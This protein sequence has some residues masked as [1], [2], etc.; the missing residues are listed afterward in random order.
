MSDEEHDKEMDAKRKKIAD[1]V[2]HKMVDKGASSADI[3]HQ[4]KV[5]KETLGHEGD[6]G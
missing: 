2:I 1:N 4:Q 3:A 5:N 6:V